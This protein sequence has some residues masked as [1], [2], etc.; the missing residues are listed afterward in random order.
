LQ[1]QNR[2][3]DLENQIADRREFYNDTVTTFN[4]RIQQ[5]PDK[6]L[7]D[8]LAYRPAELF[9]VSEEERRDVEIKFA[10]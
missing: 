10:A 3:S 5:I 9:A 1:V 8:W 4:T 2:I 7:A 6:L